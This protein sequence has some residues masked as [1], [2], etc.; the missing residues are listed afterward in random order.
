MNYFTY[1]TNLKTGIS[2]EGVVNKEELDGYKKQDELGNIR[3]NIAEPWEERL[4]GSKARQ[5]GSFY[6]RLRKSYNKKHG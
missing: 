5:N 4:H 3:L 2:F 6:E 1:Y